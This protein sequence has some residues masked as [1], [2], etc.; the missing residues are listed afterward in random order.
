MP[1]RFY[2]LLRIAVTIGSIDV[3]IVESKKGI[4]FWVIAFGLMAII[5]NPIIPVYLNSKSICLP[6]DLLCS[7]LFLIKAFIPK[8][9]SNKS[10]T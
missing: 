7:I 5:F 3:I 4:N 8:Q 6:I 2:P 10:K 9:H 1:I